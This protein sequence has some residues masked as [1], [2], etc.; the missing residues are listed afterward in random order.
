MTWF[1]IEVWKY[2]T[3]S[4]FVKKHDIRSVKMT[5]QF[6]TCKPRF[7]KQPAAAEHFSKTSIC[8]K[9]RIFSQKSENSGGKIYMFQNS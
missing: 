9:I 3:E 6:K 1:I 2:Q 4:K 7:Y 8:I 5:I